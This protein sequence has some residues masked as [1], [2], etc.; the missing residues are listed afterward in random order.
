MEFKIQCLY[1]TGQTS[2][3]LQPRV[4]ITLDSTDIGISFT[5]GSLDNTVSIRL[6]KSLHG[7][8]KSQCCLGAEWLTERV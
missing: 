3:A 4:A 7:H 2:G 5:A 8:L 6:A 1:G